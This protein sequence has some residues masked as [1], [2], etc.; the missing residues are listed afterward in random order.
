MQIYYLFPIVLIIV[1][2]AYSLYAR[3]AALK[4]AE[5]MSP[6]EAARKFTEFWG[7]YFDLGSAD[8]LAGV[9]SGVEFHAPKSLGQKAGG[10]AKEAA[11]NVIG[12]STYIPT[13]HIGLTAE[14]KVLVSREYSEMGDRGNFKQILSLDAGTR[15][16]GEGT[17]LGLA[18]VYG[19]IKQHDGSIWCYSEEGK[20]TTFKVHLPRVDEPETLV[21][22][23]KTAES[24]RGDETI[25]VVEDN[26]QVR[27]LAHHTLERLGYTLLQAQDGQQAKSVSDSY[28]GAIDLLLTDVVMPGENGKALAD[29]LTRDRPDLKVLFMSGYTANAIGPH[30]VLKPGVA[31]LQKPF[32]PTEL[33]HKVQSML[34]S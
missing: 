28:S 30:G 3:K 25:L 33:A 8:Q 20:G 19:I 32:Q 31:F 11:L 22:Q 5:N 9:W 23:E 10:V 4:A 24:P 7:S 18:T 34:A 1:V 27:T 26:D 2:V 17:G 21:I 12:V 16:V 14:G 13:V 29:R 15:A 6:E